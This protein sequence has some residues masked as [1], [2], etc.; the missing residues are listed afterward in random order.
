MFRNK[1]NQLST[2]NR[3]DRKKAN[4]KMLNRTIL[5]GS[6]GADPEVFCSSEGHPVA[7]F[8]PAFRVSQDKTG[9]IKRLFTRK[10][11]LQGMLGGKGFACPQTVK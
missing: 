6:L 2:R 8:N 11:K 9:W 3:T 4:P 10:V 5:T 7:S 1:P